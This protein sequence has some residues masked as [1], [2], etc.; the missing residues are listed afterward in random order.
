MLLPGDL[1]RDGQVT[2]SDV[3]AL[4]QLI[5]RGDADAAKRLTGN[6]DDSDDSLTVADVVELR[7]RIVAG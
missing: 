7:K 3:V 6:L 1:N 4:R 5:V 2:V